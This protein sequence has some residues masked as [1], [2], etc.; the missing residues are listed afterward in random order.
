MG[1][2]AQQVARRQRG[3]KIETW[4]VRSLYRAARELVKYK[5]DLVGVRD[6]RWDKWGTVR[7]VDCDFF[8]GKEMK[9]INW[10]QVFYAVE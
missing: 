9:I 3:L 6:F 8:Y 7:T 4:K 1:N 2:I 10:E 5:L